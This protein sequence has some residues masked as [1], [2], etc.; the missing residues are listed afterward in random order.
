MARDTRIFKEEFKFDNLKIGSSIKFC[1]LAEGVADIYPRFGRT[2][3]WDTAA[4][5]AIQIC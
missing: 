4:G 1:K 5:R 2:M 3:E